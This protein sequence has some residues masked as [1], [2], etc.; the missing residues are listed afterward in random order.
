MAR[1]TTRAPSQNSYRGD[2]GR[3]QTETVHVTGPRGELI[4]ATVHT[5]VDAVS[6]PELGERLLAD[7]LNTIE[8]DGQPLH[9][10]VPVL[11]HDPAAEVMA[12]V[13]A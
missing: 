2:I 1:G 8:L 5:T 7:T 9:V 4:A 11:Y 13:L 12:L 6:D 10:A 3:T